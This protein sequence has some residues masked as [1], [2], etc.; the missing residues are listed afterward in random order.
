MAEEADGQDAGAADVSSAGVDPGGPSRTTAERGEPYGSVPG[1]EHSAC[2][3]TSTPSDGFRPY[4]IALFI[5]VATVLG[6]LWL[7][8]KSDAGSALMQA[9]G[10]YISV[11]LR[12]SDHPF[13]D[14]QGPLL[15]AQC[16]RLGYDVLQNN[17]CYPLGL[18][19]YSPLLLYVPLGPGE[20]TA[21][22][23]TLDGMF[24]IAAVL[25][26][27]PRNRNEL[28][29]AL[30]CMFSLATLFAIER[31]NIDV[32]IFVGIVVGIYIVTRT[33][34]GRY[35]GY[36]CHILVAALKFYPVTLV[37]L[38][39]REKPRARAI[40]GSAWILAVV[41][42]VVVFHTDLQKVLS[43]LPA[44]DISDQIGALIL[45]LGAATLFGWNSAAVAACRWVLTAA[46]I[47]IAFF[48]WQP[49]VAASGR[50]RW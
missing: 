31:A 49:R 13:L 12:F 43:F 17:P 36:G 3:E 47:T 32:F 27:R 24:V 18:F 19:N 6:G 33:R 38:L 48:R 40:C 2:H 11:G 25:V 39:L 28:L 4:A 34:H 21:V 5:I 9:L 50:T 35:L 30:A 42:F 14:I 37:G 46:C 7:L 16:T 23:F 15:A 10:K 44:I 41:L 26:L 1:I 45:P 22:G 29:Y 8:L 20:T